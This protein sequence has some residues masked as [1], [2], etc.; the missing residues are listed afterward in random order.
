MDHKFW[1]DCKNFCAARQKGPVKKERFQS[2]QESHMSAIF[3]FNHRLLLEQYLLFS[4]LVNFDV[5]LNMVWSSDSEVQTKGHLMGIYS[6]LRHHRKHI[7]YGQYKP[8][9]SYSLIRITALF[10]G[11]AT[12][13]C[14]FVWSHLISSGSFF[15]M[16]K[17]WKVW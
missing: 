8:W 12:R 16:M 15:E 10:T 13:S 11:D 14:P 6:I 4:N 1:W 17:S 9:S 7:P 2:G 5:R 3:C